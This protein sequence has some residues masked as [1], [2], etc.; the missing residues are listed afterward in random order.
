MGAGNAGRAV[1]AFTRLARVFKPNVTLCNSFLGLLLEADEYELASQV[2][3][4]M[5]LHGC[6]PEDG[7]FRPL[8][9]AAAPTKAFELFQSAIEIGRV[10]SFGLNRPLLEFVCRAA[11]ADERISSPAVAS[12]RTW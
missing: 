7:T 2:L 10:P 8:M 3:H 9:A 11:T 5:T 12:A 1:E 4:F 6:Y